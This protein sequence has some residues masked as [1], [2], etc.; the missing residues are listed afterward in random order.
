M[1]D[2]IQRMTNNF[3]LGFECTQLKTKIKSFTNLPPS[4][5]IV[6][7]TRGQWSDNY[8][9]NKMSTPPCW[10]IPADECKQQL[11][12]PPIA[13]ITKAPESCARSWDKAVW[14]AATWRWE[15]CAI[16]TPGKAPTA[17][18]LPR[19]A[20]RG[21]WWAP[22]WVS[23]ST[24]SRHPLS[25]TTAGTPGRQRIKH[26]AQENECMYVLTLSHRYT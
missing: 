23:A 21:R 4:C 12:P 14:A 25:R 15:F 3:F 16:W 26:D 5:F 19:C 24:G 2:E 9:M 17:L 22:C 6:P 18:A 20:R 11:N 10:F 13:E 7:K 8:G 1:D